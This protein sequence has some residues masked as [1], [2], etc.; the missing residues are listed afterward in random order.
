M[1]I[2]AQIT[3]KRKQNYLMSGKLVLLNGHGTVVVQFLYCYG[4]YMCE[5][6]NYVNEPNWER[7]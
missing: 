5:L 6:I 3:N 1:P 7:F 4:V 2:N